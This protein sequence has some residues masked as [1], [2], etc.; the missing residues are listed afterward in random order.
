M[1]QPREVDTAIAATTTLVADV[2]MLRTLLRDVA[3]DYGDACDHP[4]DCACSMARLVRYAREA[5]LIE[6]D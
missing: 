1:T 5:G 3:V 2:S 4:D 6:P